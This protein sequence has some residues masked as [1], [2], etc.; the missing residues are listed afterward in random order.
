M[1]RRHDL[2]AMT[3]VFANAFSRT[4]D[5][6]AAVAA[7][8]EE[9]DRPVR[10]HGLDALV[11]LVAP[12]HG[13][14]PAAVWGPS[15]KRPVSRARQDIWVI[16][17]RSKVPFKELVAA[18][19]VSPG[20]ISGALAAAEKRMAKSAEARARVEWIEAAWLLR[21]RRQVA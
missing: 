20:S 18:F 13:V 6:R 14:K 16:A 21:Q 9:A 17:R 3:L 19:G 1:S 4:R 12:A 8:L 10:P 11:D 7:V 2:D 15:R 5:L